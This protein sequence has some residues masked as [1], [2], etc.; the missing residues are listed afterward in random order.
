MITRLRSLFGPRLRLGFIVTLALAMLALM[1]IPAEVWRAPKIDGLHRGFDPML[2]YV[3]ASGGGPVDGVVQ[4]SSGA[5]S[6]SAVPGSAPFVHLATSPLSYSA[7]FSVT[8]LQAQ[9]GTEPLN[10]TIWSPATNNRLQLAFES[11]PSRRVVLQ[12]LSKGSVVE[13]TPLGVYALGQTY[14]VTASIDRQGEQ[15]HLAVSSSSGNVFS[16]RA[17]SLTTT[18]RPYESHV[19]G[20]PVRVTAGRKYSFSLVAKQMLPGTSGITVDWFQSQWITSNEVVGGWAGRQLVADAPPR[21]VFAR[22]EVAT[23]GGGQTLFG[24]L[25]F[26]PWGSPSENLLANPDFLDGERGWRREEGVNPLQVVEFSQQRLDASTSA[27]AWPGLFSATRMALSVQASSSSG[28]STVR[29][30]DYEVAITHSSWLA[31]KV[32]DWRVDLLVAALASLGLMAMLG[33]LARRMTAQDDG[34]EF[35][36]ITDRALRGEKLAPRDIWELRASVE[37]RRW[38]LA[39]GSIRRALNGRG[40]PQVVI[41]RRWLYIGSSALLIYLVGNALLAHLGSLNADIVSARVWGYVA[42]WRGP[43]SL[44]FLPN[45]SSAPAGQWLGL[46]LQEAGFPYG[47][48]LAYVFWIEGLAYRFAFGPLIGG[49]A[50]LVFDDLLRAMNALF[51]LADTVVIFLILREF[52]I[53]RRACTTAAALFM[54]SP[55][56][57]FAGDVW[58]SSQSVSVV[59]LLLAVL[60]AK[61]RS[62]SWAWGFLLAACMTRPQNLVPAAIL[63]VYLLR[64]SPIRTT[65][66]S[67]AWAVIALFVLMVPLSLAVSPSLSLDVLR[68]A[69]FMHVGSGN[70]TWTLPVSW[71]GLSVWPL[72]AQLAGG[73]HGVDRILFPATT[74]LVF[75]LSYYHVGT[76]IVAASLCLLAIWTLV[77]ARTPAGHSQFVLWMA[78]AAMALFTLNTGTPTY[79]YLLALTLVFI[80][81]GTLPRLAYYVAVALLSGTTFASMYAM[82]AYWLSVHPTWSVGVYNPSLLLTRVVANLPNE[83]WFVTSGVLANMVVLA[84]LVYY[85]VRPCRQALLSSSPSRDDETPIH[86]ARN[87]GGMA[88]D[89]VPAPV[90]LDGAVRDGS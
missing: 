13:A 27:A 41:S 84:V 46:P 83:D 86:R 55:A 26:G 59:F 73:V 36:L 24:Q 81:L 14:E 57:W 37:T 32:N 66:R 6:L 33:S 53:T 67:L 72:V 62:T 80:T 69:L 18:D 54:F 28:L 49:G 17:L 9:D 22:V 58:G 82:G 23:A 11:E 63:A 76:L 45:L 8:I 3:D 34:A 71:G 7:R 47:G 12:R 75:G 87:I 43:A 40:S 52:G 85:A 68:N 38:A 89:D 10:L 1:I 74:P 25:H 60:C 77:K 48:I 30:R 4:M 50:G 88:E 5:L 51:A 20:S 31:T 21:A 78:I 44:Y 90:L 35:A 19:I 16:G 39:V 65:V 79:E 29:L 70:D 64:A 56:V 2:M 61:R 42:A 15:A